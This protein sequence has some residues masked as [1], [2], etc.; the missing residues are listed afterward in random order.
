MTSRMTRYLLLLVVLALLA[1]CGGTNTDGWVID[2]TLFVPN[3]VADL[4]GRLYHWGDLP[5]TV[6]FELPVAWA[7]IFGSDADLYRWAAAEWNGEREMIR[8]LSSSSSADVSVTF[9]SQVALGGTTWG[10][11][12]FHYYPSTGEMSDATVQIALWDRRGD[13]I[14]AEDIQ[15]IIAHELGHALGI[16]GHSMNPDDLMYLTHT[17]G[18][19]NSVGLR[20]MNTLKTAYSSYFGRALVGQEVV[21]SPGPL[22]HG[23]IE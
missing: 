21:G 23:V 19:P 5:M 4:D 8:I 14:A 18:S 15:A 9:V 17:F 11:T 20:D 22:A 16:G 3:Y 7:A 2:A 12:S 10:R 13:P 1:G 6:H